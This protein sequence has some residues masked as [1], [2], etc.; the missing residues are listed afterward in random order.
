ML[1]PL[2]V[3]RDVETI[4]LSN[5]VHIEIAIA[6]FRW[7]RGYTYAAMLATSS[8]FRRS[9]G[10]VSNPDV[11]ILRALRPGM[12]TIPGAMLLMASSPYAARRTLQRLSPSLR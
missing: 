1:E 2:I 10:H 4:E 8:R 3:R 7:T 5:R 9:A 11:E 6:S 12:V